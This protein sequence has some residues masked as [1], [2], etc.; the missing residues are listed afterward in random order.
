[1][2][3]C[4]EVCSFLCFSLDP[5]R[6]L[7]HCLVSVHDLVLTMMYI[8]SRS[9]SKAKTS[10]THYPIK[11]TDMIVAQY[12]SSLLDLTN[13]Q[14]LIRRG[15]SFTRRFIHHHK[16]VPHQ[17]DTDDKEEHVTQAFAF[18]RLLANPKFICTCCAN[19]LC[20]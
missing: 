5:F 3:S 12:L 16:N 8:Q 17:G 9:S 1:M 14:H 15:A 10:R 19:A 2:K 20:F 11:G 6:M 4:C 13:I 18:A 7:L